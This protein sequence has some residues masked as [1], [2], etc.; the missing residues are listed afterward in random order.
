MT[1]PVRYYL[2]RAV[3]QSDSKP[4]STRASSKS[5]EIRERSLSKRR[6]SFRSPRFLS[7]QAGGGTRFFT[8]FPLTLAFDSNGFF[9]M[10]RQSTAEAQPKLQPSDSPRWIPKCVR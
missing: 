10:G 8:S 7:L 3:G 5:D 4:T 6:H 9:W 2:R 1:Q